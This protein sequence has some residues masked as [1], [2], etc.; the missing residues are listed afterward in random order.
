MHHHLGSEL[1]LM[2]QAIW[3]DPDLLSR[4]GS[5][6]EGTGQKAFD[7]FRVAVSVDWGH[8]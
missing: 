6:S 3:L 5:V 2:L 8:G 1:R 4:S 7:Q